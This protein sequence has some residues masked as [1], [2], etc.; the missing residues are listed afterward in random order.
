M[1]PGIL[2]FARIISKYHPMCR[3]TVVHLALSF[4]NHS[5]SELS[6]QKIQGLKEQALRLL[7][8]ACTQGLVIE[9]LGHVT[10]KLRQGHG[11]SDLDSSLIRYFIE[12]MLDMVRP[13]FSLPFVRSMGSLLSTKACV[14]ALNSPH[15]D[16]KKNEML[17]RM[18]DGMSTSVSLHAAGPLNYNSTSKDETLAKNLKISYSIKG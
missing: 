3:N 1:A 4:L 2:S 8:I 11:R 5:N 18:I 12:G 13:P 17:N 6:Y 10:H 7:L 9:I 14:E 15:F 16:M